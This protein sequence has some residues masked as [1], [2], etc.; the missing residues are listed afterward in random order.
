MSCSC[1]KRYQSLPVY[2]CSEV[3]EPPPRNEAVKFSLSSILPDNIKHVTIE[4]KRLLYSLHKPLLNQHILL[5]RACPAMGSYICLVSF[6]IMLSPI[7]TNQPPNHL[8]PHCLQ[9]S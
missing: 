3:R 6:C 2:S 5:A 7:Q 4:I 8:T 9:L 1:E